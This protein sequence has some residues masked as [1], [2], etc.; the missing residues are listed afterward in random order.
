MQYCENRHD[1][2][3]RRFK[4]AQMRAFQDISELPRSERLRALGARER[5][6]ERGRFFGEPLNSQSCARLL[7]MGEWKRFRND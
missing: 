1:G 5:A 2:A 7:R 3:D 6:L 4:W